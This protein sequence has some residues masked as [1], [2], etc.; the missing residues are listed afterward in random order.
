M[1]DGKCLGQYLHHIYRV[2]SLPGLLPDLSY[3]GSWPGDAGSSNG[4][5]GSLAGDVLALVPWADTLSH[6]SKAGP[7]SCLR[8]SHELQVSRDSIGQRV[9]GT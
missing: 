6:C 2:A 7:E 1:L 3:F 9:K 8:F 4:G 5:S